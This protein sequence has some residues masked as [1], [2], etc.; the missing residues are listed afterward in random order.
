M[1]LNEERYARCETPKLSWES[2]ENVA[3][4]N[5]HWKICIDNCLTE[6]SI[7][8]LIHVSTEIREQ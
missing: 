7:Y 5:C 3:K 6:I 8:V 2:S 4:E 1:K